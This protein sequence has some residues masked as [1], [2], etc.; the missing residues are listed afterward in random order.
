MNKVWLSL[1]LVTFTSTLL[2]LGAF[3]IFVGQIFNLNP[4]P[5]YLPL[6]NV[7]I[8]I[9]FYLL[10]L[11]LFVAWGTNLL[12]KKFIDSNR[13]CSLEYIEYYIQLAKDVGLLVRNVDLN[14]ED[15]EESLQQ[16][17]DELQCELELLLNELHR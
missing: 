10:G 1:S 9:V 2:T 5:S 6:E 12:L 13:P 17:Q 11:S 7:N 15:K 8:R 4:G 16:A 3:F 14:D